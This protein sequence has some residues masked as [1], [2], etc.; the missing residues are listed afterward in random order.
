MEVEIVALGERST[1]ELL[2]WK[3]SDRAQVFSPHWRRLALDLIQR[4]RSGRQ[5]T[6]EVYLCYRGEQFQEYCDHDLLE[7][8]VTLSREHGWGSGIYVVLDSRDPIFED[9]AEFQDAL[10]EWFH[11]AGRVGV[12][13]FLQV[14]ID[15]T[16]LEPIDPL[17]LRSACDRTQSLAASLGGVGSGSRWE[18][19]LTGEERQREPFRL[20]LA[21][22]VR[23]AGPVSANTQLLVVVPQHGEA[24]QQILVE[25]ALQLFRPAHAIVATIG[26]RPEALLWEFCHESGLGLVWFRGLYELKYFLLRYSLDADVQPEKA[27]RELPRG[28]PAG[29][30]F[31]Y[32]EVGLCEV[33]H[34]IGREN[35][36]YRRALVYEERLKVNIRET[37]FLAQDNETLKAQRA[38][39]V[40]HWNELT[41]AV[42]GVSFNGLCDGSTH[43]NEFGQP[44]G[45][46][47]PLLVT[48]ALDPATQEDLCLL[49]ARII[50]RVLKD[51]PALVAPLVHL[52]V[53]RS[54]LGDMIDGMP[55]IAGW[56]YI[57]LAAEAEGLQDACSGDFVLVEDWLAC[58]ARLRSSFPLAL[59]VA[60]ASTDAARRFAVPG[61]ADC[62]IGF[63]EPVL[64]ESFTHPAR[65]VLQEILH[66]RKDRHHIESI[67]HQASLGVAF[68]VEE[69]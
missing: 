20:L 13:D 6:G 30:Q 38:E 3:I 2:R 26:V 54:V 40:D 14:K 66:G 5:R 45:A 1:E 7:S 4:A 15:P 49:A 36:S 69:A 68:F 19:V 27:P 16:G 46:A 34:R 52:A 61:A 21:P 31:S 39:I 63:R 65:K 35:P 43:P 48:T 58:F 22:F 8:L 57:G 12:K 25:E 62:S 37:R 47:G 55:T 11:T 60:G 10:E 42:L 64:S 59:F 28:F 41:L 29:D 67:L 50:G 53:T 51:V 9:I 23:S 56:I 33:F 24:S 32:Y 44:V 18:I 17:L